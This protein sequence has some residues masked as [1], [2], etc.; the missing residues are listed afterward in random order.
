MNDPKNPW[1]EN[2]W[3]FV[4]WLDGCSMDGLQV[5]KISSFIS[6][7]FFS[8]FSCFLFLSSHIFFFFFFVSWFRLA[9]SSLQ[10]NQALKEM[11][12]SRAIQSKRREEPPTSSERESRDKMTQDGIQESCSMICICIYIYIS[13]IKHQDKIYNTLRI[14]RKQTRKHHCR[15]CSRDNK[16]TVTESGD[17]G[18]R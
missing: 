11:G 2:R 16:P 7:S 18:P 17:K 14:G 6:F 8:L 13:T 4:N 12:S 5:Y 10:G 9:S 15:Q 1:T 3:F